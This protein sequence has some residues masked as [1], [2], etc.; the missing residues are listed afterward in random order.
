MT[1]T[2]FKERLQQQRLKRRR[3]LLALYAGGI[4]AL[5]GVSFV[6]TLMLQVVTGIQVVEDSFDFEADEPAVAIPREPLDPDQPLHVLIVGIDD[7][8]QD[9]G[10]LGPSARRTDTVMLLTVDH[11]TGHV[12]IMS[13]PRDTY[14]HI[15]QAAV[16]E[17]IEARGRNTVHENPTKMSHVH[18][19]GGPLLAMAAA[20]DLLGV[21]IKRFVRLDFRGFERLI[22]LLGGIEIDVERDMFYED[23]YQDLYVDIK[24]GRQVLPGEK[25]LQYARFRCQTLEDGTVRCGGDIERIRRQQN[26]VTALVDRTLRLNVL[27][28]LPQMVEEVTQNMTTNLSSGELLEL[29]RMA[30]AQAANYDPKRIEMGIVPGT[31]G[32]KDRVSYW[33][34]DADE[35]QKENSRVIWGVDPGENAG[36]EI[37]IHNASGELQA[38]NQLGSQLSDLG[39]QVIGVEN[40]ADPLAT[41]QV[42]DHDRGGRGSLAGKLVARLVGRWVPTA[43]FYRQFDEAPEVDIT[44]VIG[45]DYIRYNSHSE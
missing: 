11:L 1:Q 32:Y 34:V 37:A 38:G 8:T 31:D 5:F 24:K 29:M 27:P 45:Q 23:P 6:I 2:S 14:V 43:E 26:F 10:R 4:V 30:A 13:V 41:T 40:G 35:L 12:G 3:W 17:V 7:G 15:P 9:N 33:F 22:D 19:Y 25:A 21:E 28:R 18:A 39:Y 20:S 44:I 16:N 36:V 42:I